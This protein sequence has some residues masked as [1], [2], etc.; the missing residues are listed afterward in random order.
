MDKMQTS[1]PITNEELKKK[2]PSNFDLAN[3]AI[4][5]AK[6]YIKEGNGKTLGE[7]LEELR[8]LKEENA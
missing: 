4:Q 2:F 5:L 8:K 7:I 6:S 1:H 3:F